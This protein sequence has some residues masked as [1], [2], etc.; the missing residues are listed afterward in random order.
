MRHIQPNSTLA[1]DRLDA[2]EIALRNLGNGKTKRRRPNV[3]QPYV[4]NTSADGKRRASQS[5]GPSAN[6]WSGPRARATGDDDS[7]K[8]GRPDRRSG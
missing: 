1:D 8:I 5:S 2:V 4:R 6:D 3:R 7:D